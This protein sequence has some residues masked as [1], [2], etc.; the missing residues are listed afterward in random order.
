M[1]RYVDWLSYAR[2]LKPWCHCAKFSCVSN[3][4]LH[5]PRKL[6][7]GAVCLLCAMQQKRFKNKNKNSFAFVFRLHATFLLHERNTFQY[8]TVEP[9]SGT[10][11][12]STTFISQS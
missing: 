9:L 5:A 7:R 12:L 4:T 10:F 2:L 6:H 8:C 3:A 1:L 11:S